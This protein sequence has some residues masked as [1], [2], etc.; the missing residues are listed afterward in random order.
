MQKQTTNTGVLLELGVVPLSL[1]AKKNAFKNWHRISKI[2][3]ANPLVLLSYKYALDQKL[4][5]PMRSKSLLTEIGMMDIFL[6]KEE[7]RNCHINI[8]Q[9]LQD[10]F[11]QNAFTEINQPS[12]KLRTYKHLKTEIGT[13]RYLGLIPCPVKRAT[14]SKFRLSNHS[15]MIEKG[16]HI[17][18]RK[19]QRFCPICPNEIED[20]K[21]FLLNCEG[22]KNERRVFFD[23][24]KRLYKDFEHLDDTAKFIFLLTNDDA[25]RITA[26][27]I[28]ENFVRRECLLLEL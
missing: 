23:I 10:I 14:M 12:S 20:E 11:H 7:D 5:W 16:R 17:K 8:F 6:S 9:R 4:S 13:E 25:V 26:Q 22:Y 15:L 1:Y 19:E 18:I 2:K 27:F 21:H 28:S 3:A 24:V